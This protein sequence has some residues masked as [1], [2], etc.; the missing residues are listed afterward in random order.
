[1][2]LLGLYE[3][4]SLKYCDTCGTR[5]IKAG[6]CRKC[7]PPSVCLVAAILL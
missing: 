4:T 3:T 2:A 5:C 7:N 6:Q 1:M